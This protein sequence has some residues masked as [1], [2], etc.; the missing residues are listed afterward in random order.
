MDHQQLKSFLQNLDSPQVK[1]AVTDIDGVLRGKTLHKKKVIKAL[2]E[3]FGFCD[4]IFGWDSTDTLYP[5]DSVTGW[6]RGFPDSKAT[7]QVETFRQLPW[8]DHIPFILADFEHSLP[9]IC[10]RSLLKRQAEKAEKMGYETRFSMEFEWFN[11]K[12]DE[13]TRKPISD[14]MFGYSILRSSQFHPFWKQLFEQLDKAN[15][16]LEGLHTET[17]PGVME[18]AI[19]KKD[20]L[21]AADNAVLF[22]TFVKAIASQ[23]DILAT[24]MAKWNTEYPGCSGHMH[25]SLWK[26]SNLF[27][28][29]DGSLNKL[30]EH[31]LAGILHTM[32]YL[33]PIYAPTINSY[34]RLIPGSWAPTIVSWGIDNRTTACRIIQGGSASRIELRVPGSDNNPYLSMAAALASGLYGI[35]NKL[36]LSTS[37]TKGNA[38]DDTNLKPLPSS[39]K[40]AVQLMKSSSLPAELLGKEFVDH[41]IMTREWEVSLYERQVSDW[42][43]KRYFEGI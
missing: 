1:V 36:P 2:D 24:F 7:L 20:V 30:T 42:E 11:F 29:S 12:K 15:I 8:D 22:K 26:D 39:L 19:D 27:N 5:T 17:G 28:S 6:N 33:M 41:F 31:Y 23:H 40:E 4:V 34:K 25:Q 16:T 3:G 9:N 35:E 32:P 38:Y 18:A 21:S 14:G 43:M 10:P 13:A 37:L